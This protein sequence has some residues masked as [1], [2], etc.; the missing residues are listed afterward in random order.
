M[1]NR[2]GE[3]TMNINLNFKEKYLQFRFWY[4][5]RDARERILIFA[6]GWAIFYLFFYYIFYSHLDYMNTFYN[7]DISQK[8]ADIASWNKQLDE[9]KTISV[10]PLYKKW[11]SEQKSE[12]ILNSQY[13]NFTHVSPEKQWQT[14]FS[15]ILQTQPNITLLGIKNLPEHV[16]NPLNIATTQTPIFAQPLTMTVE[17]NYYNFMNYL[18]YLEKQLP[19]VHWDKLTYQVTTY[20]LAKI[21]MEFSIL[22]EKGS[23]T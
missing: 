4:E 11:L 10:S 9:I 15:V 23:T 3:K 16:Y 1:D 7:A 14:V 6:L 5:Q 18:A 17:G 2:Y 22:Y 19:N 12:H 20:P 13:S 21:D 8:K